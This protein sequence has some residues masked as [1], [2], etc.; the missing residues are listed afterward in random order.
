[1]QTNSLDEAFKDLK[2][3]SGA[4]V[5]IFKNGAVIFFWGIPGLSASLNIY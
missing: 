4:G 3:F 5:E 1:M 2:R